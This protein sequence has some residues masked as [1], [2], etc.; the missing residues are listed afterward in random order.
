MLPLL[1]LIP[2]LRCATPILS[3][4][5]SCA[6]SNFLNKQ[7]LVESAG[8]TFQVSQS[9]LFPL[10]RVVTLS[11]ISR[12]VTVFTIT[13]KVHQESCHVDISIQLPSLSAKTVT[14]LLLRPCGPL[15]SWKFQPLNDIIFPTK[16][17]SNSKFKVQKKTQCSDVWTSWANQENPKCKSSQCPYMKK[18]IQSIAQNTQR[19]LKQNRPPTCVT[20]EH[21]GDSLERSSSLSHHLRHLFVVIFQVKQGQKGF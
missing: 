19:N 4:S 20:L 8:W 2:V 15:K 10:I 17:Q 21:K 9:F 18:P 5:I 6:S 11:T 3:G 13:K 12:L 14:K 1:D 7:T 16:K